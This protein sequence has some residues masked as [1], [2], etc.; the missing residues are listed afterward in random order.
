MDGN[1]ITNGSYYVV[2]QF[3]N[4]LINP[5]TSNTEALGANLL[6]DTIS[7]TNPAPPSYTLVQIILLLSG[8]E[9]ILLLFRM[10]FNKKF[11]TFQ[12]EVQTSTSLVDNLTNQCEPIPEEKTNSQS[13]TTVINSV[14]PR[15]QLIAR[16]NSNVSRF[17][18]KHKRYSSIVMTPQQSQS[19]T[20]RSSSAPPTPSTT[21]PNLPGSNS[22][23]QQPVAK[24][25]YPFSVN[26]EKGP[27]PC[28]VL[29]LARPSFDIYVSSYSSM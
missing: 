13:E 11:S 24:P 21:L 27:K 3:R 9:I 6:D 16:F 18:N 17:S 19:T 23:S 15:P 29:V 7:D 10:E 5:L 4:Y 28:V 26:V 14:I 22:I 8:S 1:K 20:R 12:T 25:K 2:Q